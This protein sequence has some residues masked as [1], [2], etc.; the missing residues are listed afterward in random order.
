M[1]T[2]HMLERLRAELG[3]LRKTALK[4]F[5]ACSY[6]VRGLIWTPELYRGISSPKTHKYH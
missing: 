2:R 4:Y 1:H 5:Y 3:D 6:E